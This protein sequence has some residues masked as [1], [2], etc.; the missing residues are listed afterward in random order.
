MSREYPA[1]LSWVTEASVAGSAHV[2]VLQR[3]EELGR[4]LADLSLFSVTKLENI[5]GWRERRRL[6][7]TRNLGSE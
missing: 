5:C 3:K 7:L 6:R 2:R 1:Q 4:V